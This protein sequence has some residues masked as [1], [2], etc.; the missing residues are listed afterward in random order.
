MDVDTGLYYY[1]YRDYSPLDGRW[2][3]CDPIEE[4][5]GVNLYTFISNASLNKFDILGLSAEP[6]PLQPLPDPLFAPYPAGY[7]CTCVAEVLINYATCESLSGS[8]ERSESVSDPAD[9]GEL[10]ADVL[11][12]ARGNAGE[13]LPCCGEPTGSNEIA[14]CNCG[15]LV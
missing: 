4:H 5:G 12:E 15:V 8:A 13:S 3:S 2:L 14:H 6:I 7:W 9:K 11:I 10:K 1:G